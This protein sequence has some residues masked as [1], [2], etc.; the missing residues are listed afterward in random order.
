M[1]LCRKAVLFKILPDWYLSCNML[2]GVEGILVMDM[3]EERIATDDEK[4][5]AVTA[6]I[7]E[8]F[9]F[10]PTLEFE[11]KDL[12]DALLYAWDELK[13]IIPARINEIIIKISSLEGE[14]K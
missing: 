10:E 4:Q 14:S 7:R 9:S 6:Y 5:T 12:D 2:A 11:Y 13:G 8:K 1:L 3:F